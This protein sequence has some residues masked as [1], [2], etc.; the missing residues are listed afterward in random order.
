MFRHSTPLGPVYFRLD[1]EG[2]ITELGFGDEDAP[3]P[4]DGPAGTVALQLD[5]YFSGKRREFELA[6]NPE[7]TEFQRRVWD[8]LLRIP[9]GQTR[10]Y[11]ELA[12]ELGDIKAVRAVGMANGANPI[13]ILVPCHRV[14]GAGGKLVGYAA[15]VERK[16][17]LLE[18]EGV[19]P[20]TLGL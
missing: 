11:G 4:T 5:D 9:Y 18:L 3:P 16:R 10:T 19:L 20:P 2:A 1:P 12:A 7:G 13:A 6:F 17:W 14:I 8:A 15:G